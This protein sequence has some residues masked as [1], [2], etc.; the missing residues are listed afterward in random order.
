MLIPG[1]TRK[2]GERTMKEISINN[3]RTFCTVPEAIEGMAWNVLV[4]AMDD[5][6]REKVADM[7]LSTHEEFLAEYLNQAP[8]DLIVG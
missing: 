2:K 6:T 1:N 8:C 5:S 7:G 3:G 4:M